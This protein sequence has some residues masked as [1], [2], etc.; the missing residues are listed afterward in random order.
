MLY[1][2]FSPKIEFDVF[3]WNLRFF[4]INLRYIFVRA[5]KYALP[6]LILS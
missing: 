1:N 3:I 2:I 6:A 5:K 4:D